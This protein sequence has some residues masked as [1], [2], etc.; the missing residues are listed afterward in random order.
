[1]PLLAG[2]GRELWRVRPAVPRG[3]RFTAF[4]RGGREVDVLDQSCIDELCCRDAAAYR[5]YP[6]NAFLD[7]QAFQGYARSS[8]SSRITRTHGRARSA[9]S[10]RAIH[11]SP[12]IKNT[13]T[14]GTLNNSASTSRLPRF[15]TTIWA[16]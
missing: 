16:G 3:A 4:E 10:C 1:M 2:D 14:S 6:L 11:S 8:P 5:R 9:V 15:D 12:A 7:P 13:R